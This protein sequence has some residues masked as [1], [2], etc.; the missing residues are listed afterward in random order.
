MRALKYIKDKEARERVNQDNLKRKED[1]RVEVWDDRLYTSPQR[2]TLPKAK[3]LNSI[4]DEKS[5]SDVEYEQ[6]EDEESYEEYDEIEYDGY[7]V[8]DNLPTPTVSS[9]NNE[10]YI[11]FLILKTWI[12]LAHSS[13]NRNDYADTQQDY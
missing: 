9:L 2:P 10:T 3:Y 12:K 1:K 6:E 7:A 11:I 5:E 13:Y 8:D 4:I